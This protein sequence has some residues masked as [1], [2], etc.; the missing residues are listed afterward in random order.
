NAL[1]RS[2]VHDHSST[3]GPAVASASASKGGDAANHS[4]SSSF[5]GGAA[6]DQCAPRSARRSVMIAATHRW[7]R[8]MWPSRSAT[9]HSG[10]DGTR[11][12]TAPARALVASALPSRRIASTRCSKEITLHFLHV[13]EELGPIVVGLVDERAHRPTLELVVG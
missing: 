8:P 3:S 4:S 7:M 10:H 6:S 2:G 9:V 5:G 1:D 11:A 13:V 12:S